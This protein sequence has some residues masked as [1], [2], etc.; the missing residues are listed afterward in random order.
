MTEMNNAFLE[1]EQLIN[2]SLAELNI[3]STDYLIER[4]FDS[5]NGDYACNVAMKLFPSAKSIASSPKELAEKISNIIK[6]SISKNISKVEVAG[7]GFINFY[8]SNDFFV[9]NMFDVRD[10]NG[11]KL[12]DK[13]ISLEHTQINPNKEPHIGHLRNACIGDSLSKILSF[14]G[15]DVTVQYYQND[16]GQQIASIVLAYNKQFIPFKDVSL[17]NCKAVLEWASRAYVDIEKRMESSTELK[18][19]KEEIQR[20]I[21]AQNSEDSKIAISITDAILKATL[22]LFGHLSIEYDLVV[23]ESDIIKNKLWEATFDLL[24]ASPAFYKS[25][26]GGRVGCWLVKMPMSDDKV[27]V[28]SNGIPTY[29]GN[30]IAYHLWKF[31]VIKDFKYEVLDWGTQDSLLYATDSDNGETLNNVFN[32][33][34]SIVN[35]IDTTQ[36]YPQEGVKEA[37]RVLGY[38]KYADNYHH[39]NYGF[40][41]LKDANSESSVVKMSGRKG[42]VVTISTFIET[43]RDS[44][45]NQFGSFSAID[46]VVFGAIKFELL[47]YDTYQDITFD[48]SSALDQKGFSGPY[49]QY[50]YARAQSVMSKGDIG[51][52]SDYG[53]AESYSFGLNE[54]ELEILKLLFRFEDIIFRSANESAPHYICKYLFDLSKSFNAFYNSCKIIGSE[55]EEFRLDLT[56]STSI[57]LSRCM[58]LIGISSPDSLK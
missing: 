28:R 21:V 36:T 56:L 3:S 6:K 34:E 24:K 41:F 8:L 17:E 52:S 10:L 38:S 12:S 9:K 7:P 53:G 23:K 25:T 54:F 19:E 16:V 22:V 43:L 42:T 26:K 5:A 50:T 37:L 55:Q 39:V 30:D 29:T 47:K 31:G 35:I 15:N 20:R 1:I 11:F 48:I 13:K 4:P 51:T 49:V 57:V 27:I 14:V 46:E 58:K 33:A 45:L 44:L 40:V 32:S 2:N 18:S